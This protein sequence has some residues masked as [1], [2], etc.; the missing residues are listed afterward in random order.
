MISN[1]E[2][3][4]CERKAPL[5]SA[6]ISL[7]PFSGSVSSAIAR[8]GWSVNGRLAANEEPDW[9]MSARVNDWIRIPC[10]PKS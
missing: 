9:V 1:V 4:R 10:E 8:P 5:G 6:K 3:G 2:L 7:A